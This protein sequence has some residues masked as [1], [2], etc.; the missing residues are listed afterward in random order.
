MNIKKIEN[1]LAK[2]NRVVFKLYSLE[3]AIENCRKSS[4]YLFTD[5]S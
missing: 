3:Y 1:I 4:S 2:D 5:I